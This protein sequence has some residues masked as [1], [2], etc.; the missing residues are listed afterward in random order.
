MYNQAPLPS[1]S[2]VV[3]QEIFIPIDTSAPPSAIGSRP[4]HPVPREGIVDRSTSP[5]PTNKFYANFFLGAQ[6]QGS[7]THPYSVSWAK[8]SGNAKSWGLSVSHID[9]NQRAYAPNNPASYYINPIGI[10]SIII[11]ASELGSTTALTTDSLTAFSVE[12]N[13]SVDSGSSPVISYPLVQGMGFVTGIYH[14]STPLIQSSVLFRQVTRISDSPKSGVFK[15]KILLEDGNT[16]LLYIS[17]AKGVQLDL[18]VL[19]SSIIQ[20]SSKFTGVIQVAKNPGDTFDRESKYDVAAGAY[21]TAVEISGS[22]NGKSG[23]YSLQWIKAG[24]SS[25]TLLMFALPHHLQSFDTSTSNSK[26]SIQLQATTK[27]LATGVLADS[28]T[29]IENNL[30]DDLGFAPW[31]PSL[32]SLTQLSSGAKRAVIDSGTIELS[33]DIDSQTNLDSMYFS[34]KALAK[35]ASIIYAVNDLGGDVALAQ[36]GLAKLKTAFSVFTQNIQK[37]PLVYESAWGGIVS[38]GAYVTGD[39]G[40][41]FGNTYYNDHHF[42]YG[43]FIFTAAVIGYLDPSWLPVNR[44]WVNSLIRDASNPSTSDPYFPFSRSFDWY[45]GHSWAKG[46]FESAD[47][48]DEESSSEDAFF[49]YALKMWGKVTGDA[50]TEARGNLM[51]SILSRTLDNYFLMASNNT[52]Q[53]ANFIGNKVTGILF[54]N[55]ADHAT[56]FG[57]NTEYIQGIH[58]IPINPSSALTRQR[59]FVSEE[60]DTYFSNGRVDQVVGGWKGILYANLALIDPS[61]SWNFFSQQNFDFGWIDGGASRTW[62]LAYAAGEYFGGSPLFGGNS[63]LT[64]VPSTWRSIGREAAQLLR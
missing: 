34:G 14:D 36:A 25:V 30:P 44:G 5:I 20:G 32:G 59:H 43:Y 64:S 38:S 22:V 61:T 18:Q 6:N 1:D 4:D 42:H 58:M 9:A 33:Q 17:S 39:A 27:G 19:N 52:N 28:W 55:K 21:P 40:Q 48:K 63:L 49:S 12:V 8:G 60:W 53:P 2:G 57:L 41:D 47:G 56:Y 26:T 45:H 50:S 51:L 16:W 54:E 37:Y 7:W 3:S 24:I 29:M 11:S 15:Y 13:L 23:N 35:F 62:Y 46:L 31:T 10:Q